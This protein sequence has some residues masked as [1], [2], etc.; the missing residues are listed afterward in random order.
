MRQEARTASTV[1]LA[2]ILLVVPLVARHVLPEWPTPMHPPQLLATSV[3]AG[4]IQAKAQQRAS[5]ALPDTMI[6]M[7]TLQL[8]VTLMKIDVLRVHIHHKDRPIVH[9][10]HH[11][12][13]LTSITTLHLYA[14]RVRPVD[15]NLY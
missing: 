8:R 13:Q 3:L 11:P 5:T 9:R 10:A 7:V 15:I 14:Q 12:A 6:M 1:L 2:T 4:T